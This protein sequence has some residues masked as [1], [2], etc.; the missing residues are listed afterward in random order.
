[1]LQIFIL[2]TTKWALFCPSSWTGWKIYAV[3]KQQNKDNAFTSLLA[4]SVSKSCCAFISSHTSGV[5]ETSWET[6]ILS[7]PGTHQSASSQSLQRNFT[8]FQEKLHISGHK[9][10]K[11][12]LKT[13]G[14]KINFVYPTYNFQKYLINCQFQWEEFTWKTWISDFFGKNKKI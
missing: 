10:K 3:H 2:K 7:L 14:M 6:T 11:Q 4:E 12:K 9:Y 13:S 1:M 5:S 8:T